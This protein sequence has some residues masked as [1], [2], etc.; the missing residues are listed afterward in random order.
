[1]KFVSF[2]V[3]VYL[4]FVMSGL[5]LIVLSGAYSACGPYRAKPHSGNLETLRLRAKVNL[6]PAATGHLKRVLQ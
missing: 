5:M 6:R 3:F 1:V 2:V 4:N